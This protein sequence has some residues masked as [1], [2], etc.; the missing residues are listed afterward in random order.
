MMWR[1]PVLARCRGDKPVKLLLDQ[2]LPI[3]MDRMFLPDAPLY[4]RLFTAWLEGDT[5]K[6][7]RTWGEARRFPVRP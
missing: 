4:S 1:V 5:D 3:P 2:G 7:A 6:L